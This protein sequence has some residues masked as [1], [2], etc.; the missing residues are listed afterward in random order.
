M[1]AD[2]HPEPAQRGEGSPAAQS[3]ILRGAC[4]ERAGAS[5]RAQGDGAFL[6]LRHLSKRFGGLL[7]PSSVDF[8]VAEEDIFGII[9]PNG[10]GKTTLFSCLVGALRPTSA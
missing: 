9:G 3:E 1:P 4:P 8:D 7:A 6:S 2:R 5:R 10:A